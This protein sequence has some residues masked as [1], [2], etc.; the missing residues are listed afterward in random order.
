M[1]EVIIPATT[2]NLG[3][4]FDCLGLALNLYNRVQVRPTSRLQIRVLGE[5]AN[6]L[7]KNAD[8]LLWRS[9]CHLWEQIGSESQP[10]EIIMQN[11][12]PLSRGLGSSSAAIVGG[13]LMANQLANQPFNRDE[14]VSMATEL[15]G[16]PDNVAPA[17]LGGMVVSAE[18][19]SQVLTLPFPF[20][21]EL[22]L[23]VCI[24]D[25]HLATHLARQALPTVVSHRDAVFNLSHVALLLASL[26]GRRFDLLGLAAD[27]RLHQPYR[28]GL[29]PGA[30][31][32]MHRARK[33]GALAAMISG[34][35]PTILAMVPKETSAE[36]VGQ[37]M[38]AGF[39][40]EGIPARH[41]VLH[42][43]SIGARIV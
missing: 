25:F 21:Q 42:V 17:L 36:Q 11:D 38:V 27:D 14:L 30:E 20:P 23:V 24:P 4:G 32:V 7:P 37:S 3:P 12:I 9:A 31:S 5:G 19:R 13:L 6:D 40:E 33:A 43:D 1:F 22:Q 39:L 29:I 2:A 16:H 34:A 28:L 41:L 10:V 18:N 8:N 15:E 35:G 26:V